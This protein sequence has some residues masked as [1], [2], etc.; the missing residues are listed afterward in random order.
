MARRGTGVPP[1]R[2]L[3]T[4]R[5]AR[6]ESSVGFSLHAESR[7]SIGGKDDPRLEYVGITRQAV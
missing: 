2:I 6:D 3:P 4:S 5:D 7:P 1:A